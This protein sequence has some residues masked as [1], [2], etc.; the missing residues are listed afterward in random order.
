MTKQVII[1]SD[2]RIDVLEAFRSIPPESWRI[3]GYPIISYVPRKDLG[4]GDDKGILFWMKVLDPNNFLNNWEGGE[5]DPEAYFLFI[6]H[7]FQYHSH[8]P[9]NIGIKA[10]TTRPDFFA[11]DP[12][13]MINFNMHG[14]PC[15]RAGGGIYPTLENFYRDFFNKLPDSD[16]IHYLWIIQYWRE[17]GAYSLL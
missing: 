5:F 14:L 1:E 4:L 12:C 15:E 2:T 8:N 10:V 13:N 11:R 16:N 6:L 17:V 3:A 7:H 9:G